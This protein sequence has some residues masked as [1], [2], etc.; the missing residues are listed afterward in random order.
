MKSTRE[1]KNALIG[2]TNTGTKHYRRINNIYENDYNNK[3]NK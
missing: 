1:F 3:Y 2:I